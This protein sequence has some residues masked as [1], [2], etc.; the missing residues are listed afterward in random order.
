MYSLTNFFEI[1]INFFH[2][3]LGQN[4]IR[5][6]NEIS[7]GVLIIRGHN[8][9]TRGWPCHELLKFFSKNSPSAEKCRT[10]PKM[11]IPYLYTLRRTIAYD[12]TLPNAI[13]YLNTCIAYL[14]T[15]TPY[16]NTCINY[17]NTLTRLSALGSISLYIQPTRL[18]SQE[19]PRQPI[20]IEYYVTRVVS[21]SKSSTEKTHQLRQPIRIEYYVTGELSAR[22]EDPS[23]L[24]ARVG[25]L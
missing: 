19:H 25:S 20:R 18:G 15:L 23:R 22:V 1:K 9:Y 6:R 8:I 3:A 7:A 11:N 2:I 16:L 14:N 21:Q 10:V 12:F 17:R 4:S 24:S 5:T 13:A